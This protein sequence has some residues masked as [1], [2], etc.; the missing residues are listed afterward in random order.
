LTNHQLYWECHTS[1]VEE[2][3]MSHLPIVYKR[4]MQQPQDFWPAMD[5]DYSNRQLGYASDKIPAIT[6]IMK[7]LS[8]DPTNDFL[9]F[10]FMPKRVARDILWESDGGQGST[11]LTRRVDGNSQLIKDPPS[12]SWAYWN[13]SIDFESYLQT[14]TLSNA[15]FS[16]TSADVLLIHGA[17]CSELQAGAKMTRGIEGPTDIVYS[18][19]HSNVLTLMDKESNV[20]GWGAFDL[21]P[22]RTGGNIDE[23]KVVCALVSTVA[24]GQAIE[25]NQGHQAANVL[26]LNVSKSTP[27]M[28]CRV[29]VGQVW[30]VGSVVWKQDISPL[31]VASVQE[32]SHAISTS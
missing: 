26:L 1:L 25:L 3:G 29:G 11:P 7:Q 16:A 32:P 5:R 9:K 22:N 19:R 27:G 15:T 28:F 24:W 30:D 10:G 13:G 21:N 2:G 18:A 14:A 17:Q 31:A 20:V 6:G 23:K 8:G 4:R 12:W